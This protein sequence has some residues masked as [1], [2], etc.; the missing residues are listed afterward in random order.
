[1]LIAADPI[2]T[3][4]HV[5]KSRIDITI[6]YDDLSVSFAFTFT[7]LYAQI[8]YPHYPHRPGPH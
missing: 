5:F 7:N 6:T 3:V 1:M 8:T 2:A 4:E